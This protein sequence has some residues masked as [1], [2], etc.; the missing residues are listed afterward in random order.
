MLMP[1]IFG[2]DLLEDVFDQLNEPFMFKTNSLVSTNGAMRTDIRE[3]ESA[4]ELDIDL[5][6]VTKEDVTAELEDGY[7][8]IKATTSKNDDLQ[9]ENGKY[10]RRERFYG[11]YSRS[12]YVGDQITEE[13][14]KAKFDNGILQILIP[15]KE[16]IPE[17][18]Q[19][20]TITIG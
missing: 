19:K 20:K 13:D 16:V 1:S 2:R 18:P 3:T 17:E 4:Y 14:I 5:P 12:F 6:G 11:T 15:K 9:D 10:L 8:T 7:L